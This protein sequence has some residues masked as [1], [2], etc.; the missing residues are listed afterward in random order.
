M[1]KKI[2]FLYENNTNL[3]IEDGLHAALNALEKSFK[4][5]RVNIAHEFEFDK[6]CDFVLGHGAFGS[7][8][9]ILLQSHDGKKGLCIGG[10]VNRYSGQKYDVMFYE[11]KWSRDYL[12]LKYSDALLVHAFGFNGN[13][14][15]NDIEQQ[16]RDVDYLGVGAFAK[17]KRWEKFLDKKG[18]RRVIGEFQK[19][20]PTESQEIWDM[21]EADGVICKDVMC[22]ARLA[23]E[24]NRAKTV[25]IPADINGGGERAILE[26]RACGCK[27]EIEPDNPKLLEVINM[28]L[29][30]DLDYAKKL[31]E[32]LQSC[33]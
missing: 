18:F 30:T 20:N 27:V 13:I 28:P 31:K 3:V 29:W 22:A 11:T 14:Y 6:D 32:G 7:R 8:V 17:W 21:L 9:D 19:N 26:A 4:I 23:I 2:L 24:Y 15:F 5:K 16:V 1:K 25:Y 10:N 12:D 33:L